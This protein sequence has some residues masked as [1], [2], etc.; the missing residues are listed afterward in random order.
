MVGVMFDYRKAR[1]TIVTKVAEPEVAQSPAISNEGGFKGIL[2]N[3]AG[4]AAASNL[5]FLPN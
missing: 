1:K 4:N 3:V 2:P 5:L